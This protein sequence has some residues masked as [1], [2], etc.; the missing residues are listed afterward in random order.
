MG[1]CCGAVK[2]SPPW[3]VL[4]VDLPTGEVMKLPAPK[5]FAG[6]ESSVRAK[7]PQ[8]K[9]MRMHAEDGELTAERYAAFLQ[10]PSRVLVEAL[11]ISPARPHKKHRPVEVARPATP[12]PEALYLVDV[13]K[14]LLSI[15]K[16]VSMSVQEI[17]SDWIQWECRVAVVGERL[18]VTGGKGNGRLCMQV[19]VG[20][21]SVKRCTEMMESRESHAV[22]VLGDKIYVIGGYASEEMR[23]CE[24]FTDNEWFPSCQLERCRSLHSAIGFLGW[25]YVCGGTKE[26]TIE[27]MDGHTWRILPVQL[28]FYIS[29]VG[30]SP[31]SA[32]CLLLTGG[33]S[34]KG[35]SQSLYSQSSFLLDVQREDLQAAASLPQSACFTH[36]GSLHSSAVLLFTDSAL[37]SYQRNAWTVRKLA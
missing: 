34:L 24:V 19:E 21:G 2:A 32:D 33:E 10:R 6:L 18:L 5:T 14:G 36:S 35:G 26:S 37:Y 22:A 17:R 12:P 28:P 25:I 27:V 9:Q 31:A 20:K 4:V 30:I 15:F 13:D 8:T 7:M 23:S 29:R 16:T 11:D 3:P 1:C